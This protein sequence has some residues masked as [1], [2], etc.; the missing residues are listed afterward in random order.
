M[1]VQYDEPDLT[2]AEALCAKEHEGPVRFRHQL[3]ER[4]PTHAV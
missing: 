1:L 2:D 4:V 3:E